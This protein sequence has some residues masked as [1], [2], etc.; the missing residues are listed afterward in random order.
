M[1]SL[2]APIAEG[3]TNGADAPSWMGPDPELSP[4]GLE[5]VIHAAEVCLVCATALL[6]YSTSPSFSETTLTVACNAAEGL[7]EAN[8]TLFRYLSWSSSPY[9]QLFRLVADSTDRNADYGVEIVAA[10][11]HR[12]AWVFGQEVL[13]ALNQ[14][15]VVGQTLEGKVVT[16]KSPFRNK[17]EQICDALHTVARIEYPKFLVALQCEATRARARIAAQVVPTPSTAPIS[18]LKLEDDHTGRASLVPSI[19]EFRQLRE[20][21]HGLN[22]DEFVVF[23][24]LLA[25]LDDAA[26]NDGLPRHAS[27]SDIKAVIP[28]DWNWTKFNTCAQWQGLQTRLN[29]KLKNIPLDWRVSSKKGAHLRRVKPT[30]KRKTKSRGKVTAKRARSSR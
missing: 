12:I 4:D 13:T 28:I 25:R 5:N 14:S 10:H 30:P 20:F 1:K 26:K 27:E 3:L 24:F 23:E 21:L 19:G 11:C 6:D 15:H 18:E 17:W 7:Y 8:H 22:G 16:C 2:A 9:E 29:Q